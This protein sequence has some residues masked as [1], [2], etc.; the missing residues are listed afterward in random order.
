LHGAER[1]LERAQPVAVLLLE[2]LEIGAQFVDLFAQRL[3]T[4]GVL[5]C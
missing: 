2:R 4:V 3:W 1:R 5:L